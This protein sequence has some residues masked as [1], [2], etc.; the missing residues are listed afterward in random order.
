MLSKNWK[1]NKHQ[2]PLKNNKTSTA[3]LTINQN[4][5]AQEELRIK[6]EKKGIETTATRADLNDNKKHGIQT[7]CCWRR[8]CR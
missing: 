8:W 6:K 3:A 2:K 1:E 7:S 4:Q 5:P